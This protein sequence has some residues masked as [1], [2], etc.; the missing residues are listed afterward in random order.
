MSQFIGRAE[1]TVEIILGRLFGNANVFSQ[2]SFSKIKTEVDEYSSEIQKHK[3]DFFVDRRFNP[4]LIIEVNFKHG[5]KADRKWNDIF[6][7]LIKKRGMI[8]VTI[9]DNECESLFKDKY[10]P[11]TLGDWH[12]VINE[13]IRAGVKL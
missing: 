9:D 6:T 10:H 4:A 11:I 12:D 13:L 2:V 8:P 5:E 1:P 3:F 7:P